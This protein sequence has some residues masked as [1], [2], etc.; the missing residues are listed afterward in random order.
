[1]S[2]PQK[3]VIISEIFKVQKCNWNFW[4]VPSQK[5]MTEIFEI[6]IPSSKIQFVS[7]KIFQSKKSTKIFEI[8][9]F[10]QPMEIFAIFQVEKKQ[11]KSLKFS[12]F[13]WIFENFLVEKVNWN[14]WNF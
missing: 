3:S 9:K 6:R 13:N 14:L 4:N 8:S 5:K 10:K 1:M 12:K 2:K 11:L 7:L